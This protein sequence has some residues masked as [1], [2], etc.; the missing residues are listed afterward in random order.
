VDISDTVYLVEY[1]HT[2]T[3]FCILILPQHVSDHC[4][5]EAELATAWLVSGR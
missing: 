3:F 2:V 5:S 4:F 1:L